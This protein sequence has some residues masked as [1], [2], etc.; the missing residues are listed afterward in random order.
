MSVAKMYMII[1]NNIRSPSVCFTV[2][3]YKDLIYKFAVNSAVT[4]SCHCDIN[5]HAWR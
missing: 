3:L 4:I 1:Y 2:M 5:T